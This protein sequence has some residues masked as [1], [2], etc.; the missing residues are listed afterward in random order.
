MR[1]CEVAHRS[2]RV[3]VIN[4]RHT[5]AH[6]QHLRL[7]AAAPPHDLALRCAQAGRRAIAPSMHLSSSPSTRRMMGS[8]SEPS[9][10]ASSSSLLSL[11]VSTRSIVAASRSSSS[12]RSATS[13]HRS[14]DSRR[15]NA[16]VNI[17]LHV[18]HSRHYFQLACAAPTAHAK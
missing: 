1:S 18:K 5:A 11:R 12:G 14:R 9:C 6:G 8:V 15:Y 3:R 17:C 4:A 10:S 16:P 2:Q 7:Q 13:R